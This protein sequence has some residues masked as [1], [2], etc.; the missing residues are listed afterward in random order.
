MSEKIKVGSVVLYRTHGGS[1]TGKVL[2][3]YTNAFPGPTAYVE[4]QTTSGVWDSQ[5]AV[6]DRLHLY[7]SYL[8]LVESEGVT[9]D[10]EASVD[11]PTVVHYC[12][13]CTFTEV[14][15]PTTICKWCGGH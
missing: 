7:V 2:K 8:S 5:A 11:A 12:S 15:T 6:G 10:D 13:T 9:G 1:L 3:L 14:P 4:I